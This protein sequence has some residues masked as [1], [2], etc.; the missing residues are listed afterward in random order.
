METFRD[1]IAHTRSNV[2]KRALFA[3]THTRCH[4]EDGANSLDGEDLEIEKS[5]YDEARKDGFD[6]GD[7][8]ACCH[9]HAFARYW[10]WLLF[11]A[12]ISITIAWGR[13]RERALRQERDTA[14]DDTVREGKA[15]IDEEKG[16]VARRPGLPMHA[17][18]SRPV[19]VR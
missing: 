16:C 10:C 17:V 11:A 3:Q 13:S 5:W 1:K 9:V 7:P 8:R 6:L 4:C 19:V 18:Q 15:Q 14:T 12:L 2:Y